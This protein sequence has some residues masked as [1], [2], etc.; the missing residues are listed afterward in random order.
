RRDQLPAYRFVTRRIASALTA[1]DPD[2]PESPFRRMAGAMFGSV[3]VAVL[4]VAGAGIL[5][6]LKPG[7]ST[8]WHTAGTLVVEQETNTRYVYLD[9]VLHPVLNFASARLILK[10]DPLPVASVARSSLAGVPRGLPVGIPGAPDALPDKGSLAATPWS[11][12]SEPVLTASGAL[13]SSVRVRVGT[14][15][16]G[17]QPLAGH[18]ALLVQGGDST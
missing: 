3:M 15:L 10:N 9:G 6:A 5:G 16:S 2:S 12:C 8:S 4:V 13:G 17:A 7:G 1:G 14:A 18:S 11:V